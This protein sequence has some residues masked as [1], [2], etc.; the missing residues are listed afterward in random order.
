LFRRNMR[1]GGSVEW[2]I[3]FTPTHI[4]LIDIPDPDIEG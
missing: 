1:D 3:R 2:L 4:N